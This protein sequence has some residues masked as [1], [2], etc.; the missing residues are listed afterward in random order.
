M[1]FNGVS[2]RYSIEVKRDEYFGG[3]E[4]IV[5]RCEKTT[6]AIHVICV[7]SFLVKIPKKDEKKRLTYNTLK[8]RLKSVKVYRVPS[9][10]CYLFAVGSN[11][12]L[13]KMKICIFV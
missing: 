10:I 9:Q 12:V 3:A 4:T 6:K 2:V 5:F 1:K 11:I 8:S 7:S 13:K